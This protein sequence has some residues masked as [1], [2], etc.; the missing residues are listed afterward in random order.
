MVTVA[1]EMQKAGMTMP[2]LIGG[3]TTSR[4]HT[5][6][7]IAPAY[8][9]AVVHVLDAS[10]A[11]GVA[12]GRGVAHGFRRKHGSCGKGWLR[13]CPAGQWRLG[14]ACVVGR[15]AWW[16]LPKGRGG[17]E[18]H[19]QRQCAHAGKGNEVLHKRLLVMVTSVLRKT[20]PKAAKRSAYVK[21]IFL[22]SIFGRIW[23]RPA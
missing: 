12:F 10:R 19:D 17:G 8:S 11:V 20:C 23:E 9:G 4:V 5:A 15:N 14:A 18:A 1:E 22:Y 2:L 6:L 16:N 7:R 21:H 3:A 13:R